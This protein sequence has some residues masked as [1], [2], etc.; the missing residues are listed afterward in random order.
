MQ[1][2]FFKT[3]ICGI[4]NVS[5]SKNFQ[6]FKRYCV[7][8]LVSGDSSGVHFSQLKTRQVMSSQCFNLSE[9]PWRKA[10][11]QKGRKGAYLYLETAKVVDG[12]RK[13]IPMSSETRLSPWFLF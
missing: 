1:R 2:V 6:M 3:K 10:M 12:D 7:D 5:S 11:F 4:Q 9:S 8:C 13:H